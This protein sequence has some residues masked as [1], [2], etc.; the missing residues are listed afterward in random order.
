MPASPE[1]ALTTMAT[2]ALVSVSPVAGNDFVF[3]SVIDGLPREPSI[4]EGLLQELVE[5]API[6][7]SVIL[8]NLRFDDTPITDATT[9]GGMPVVDQLTAT[10]SQMT[11]QPIPPAGVPGLLAALSGF[12]PVPVQQLVET[13]LAVQ[14]VVRW[15]I[16]DPNGGEA[17]DVYWSVGGGGSGLQ[18]VGGGFT[19]PMD[20]A[21]EEVRL[22]FVVVS[23]LTSGLPLM[24]Q[25]TVSASLKLTAGG[26]ASDWVDLPPVTIEVP[27]IPLPTMVAMFAQ[28]QLGGSVFVAV[29]SNSAL[30]G[31][32]QA[33]S[34]AVLTL[35]NALVNVQDVVDVAAFLTGLGDLAGGISQAPKFRLE[36]YDEIT[37][38]EDFILTDNFGPFWNETWDNT[39][40]SLVFIGPRGRRIQCFNA[41]DHH[42][43]E[44]A[45]EMLVT[46]LLGMIEIRELHVAAPTR[47]IEHA[48][49]FRVTHNPPGDRF[50]WK[51]NVHHFGNEM[52][53]IK[54][55]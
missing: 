50:L 1:R 16:R 55:S 17:P 21:L 7:L 45:F 12:I 23:E 32:E 31:S 25:R 18:G 49:G 11:H 51:R 8:K 14:A 5:Q 52:S 48:A 30:A 37:N 20:R 42:T 29:P 28:G 2:Q 15:S 36:F 13:T 34:D 54:F 39:M 40:S 43:N 47:D 9:I 44:G 26:F 10:L 3:T 38:F 33:V 6:D 22:T 4:T 35:S 53:G 46:G 24:T 19:P 27:V 41:P